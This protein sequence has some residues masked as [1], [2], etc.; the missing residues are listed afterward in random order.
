M[1]VIPFMSKRESILKK[2]DLKYW[3]WIIGVAFLVLL[4]Y[5][6]FN[7]TD[8]IRVLAP[9]LLTTSFLLRGIFASPEIRK[10]IIEDFS[11]KNKNTLRDIEGMR[12]RQK[13]EDLEEQI[14]TDKDILYLRESLRGFKRTSFQKFVIYSAI[15]FTITFLLTYMDIGQYIQ[16]PNLIIITFFFFSGLFYFTRMI[17]S[18]FFALNIIKTEE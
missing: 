10:S 7:P 15:L 5:I 1:K 9:I 18:I 11:R 17:N 14:R 6:K 2:L 12:E 16:M 3:M 13:M 4:T 8:F